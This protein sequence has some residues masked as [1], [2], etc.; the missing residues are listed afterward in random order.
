MKVKRDMSHINFFFVPH[1]HFRPLLIFWELIS[2]FPW[3]FSKENVPSHLP[4]IV[5]VT[6]LFLVTLKDFKVA[7]QSVSFINF[8]CPFSTTLVSHWATGSSTAGLKQDWTGRCRSVQLDKNKWEAG[9]WQQRGVYSLPLK[10]WKV[11]MENYI[12]PIYR[13]FS[14]KSWLVWKDQHLKMRKLN[15]RRK[16]LAQH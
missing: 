9:R 6:L 15:D 16:K 1:Y 3:L 7:L 4:L 14:N 5:L 13:V 11:A 10:L 2:T 8:S 12:P